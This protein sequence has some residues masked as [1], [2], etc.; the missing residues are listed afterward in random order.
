[1]ARWDTVTP[2]ET[3]RRSAL[4]HKLLE[5]HGVLTRE[6][7]ASEEV[8]GGFTALYDVLRA[9]EDRGRVRRGLFVSGL[10]AS[11]F[12]VPGADERLRA[13]REPQ[14]A[15]A[16]RVLAATDPANPFGTLLDWPETSPEAQRPQRAAGALV[17]LLDGALLAWLARGDQ[18]LTTFFDA[19]DHAK[20][21]ALGR[22]LG[23][24]VERGP[25]RMMLVSTIDGIAAALSPLAAA[26]VAA[27][28]TPGAQGLLRKRGF[29]TPRDEAR[30]AR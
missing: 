26:L 24:L 27:G 1:M 19:T 20:A 9:L 21:A 11:Q 5:R 22:A 30:R 23:D 28:F 14:P 10:S 8:D 25:R 18:A 16:A 2:S 7:L 13:L 4:V 17:F 29:V 15:T 12:A 3:E 6:A